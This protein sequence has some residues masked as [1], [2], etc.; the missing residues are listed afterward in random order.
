[1]FKAIMRLRLRRMMGYVVGV[2][3]VLCALF[4]VV[5]YVTTGTTSEVSLGSSAGSIKFSRGARGN[6][7][8]TVMT[9]NVAH[10]RGT[11]LHQALQDADA[12]RINLNKVADVFVHHDPDVI[13][14]Q[15]ADGPSVWSGDFNHVDYLGDRSG[16]FYRFRGE[17]VKGWKTSYGAAL[18]SK[19]RLHDLNS[20]TFAPS[21]PTLA[22]GFVVGVLDWPGNPS[23]RIAVVSVHLD[24]LRPSVRKTQVEEMMKALLLKKHPMILMGDFNCAWTGGE[25]SLRMLA[26]ALGLRAYEP[27]AENMA[28]F[29]NSG[30]RLDW[31][32][33]SEELQFVSYQTIPVTVSD[34]RPVVASIQ[35]RGTTQ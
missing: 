7:T 15:E 17:H 1:M 33:I 16:C 25:T 5:P 31:I 4:V 14:L 30:K 8:L 10:G 22:K 35:L 18:L 21:P 2:G 13:A 34:H 26:D 27:T 9:V 11:S 3:C 29:G 28:T 24:F 19:R 32:L 12:I 6:D 20:V 23:T